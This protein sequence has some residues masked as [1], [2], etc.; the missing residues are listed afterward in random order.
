MGNDFPFFDG[1][2]AAMDFVDHIESVHDLVDVDIFRELLERL[3]GILLQGLLY[4]HGV[5]SLC[6]LSVDAG[7]LLK[8]ALEDEGVENR[9]DGCFIGIGQFVHFFHLA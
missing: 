9:F 4:M 5:C 7:E 3:E 2:A 1:L 8:S 6:G